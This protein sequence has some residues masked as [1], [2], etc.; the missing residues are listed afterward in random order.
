MIHAQINTATGDSVTYEQR[1]E[2][3]RIFKNG[4]FIQINCL[5]KYGELQFL[6]FYPEELK[7]FM[8]T[9]EDQRIRFEYNQLVA[10]TTTVK[11]IKETVNY[12]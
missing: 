3:G 2:I 1:C 4:S 5:D 12:H 10:R 8:D 11:G 9:M 7:A 6:R